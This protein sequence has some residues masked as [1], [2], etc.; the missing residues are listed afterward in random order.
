ML[1]KQAI[2]QPL[3][4]SGPM[5]FHKNGFITINR[6]EEFSRGFRWKLGI[7][8]NPC[9]QL[10]NGK[11]CVFC[12]FLNYR[13]PISPRTVGRYFNE[14]FRNSNLSDIRRLE[15]Y[16]SGSFFD[17]KEVSFDS[18]LEIIKS[19]NNSEIEE[20]ILE[21]RPEFI[22]EENLKPITDLINPKRITIA[23]GVET[24]DDRLRDELSKGFSTKDIAKSLSKIAKAGMNFQAY[25][26]LNP[27]GINN[28]RNAIIDVVNSSK[29]LISLTKKMDCHLSLALQPFFIAKNSKVSE[30]QQ[31]YPVRPPWLYTIA[32]TL[33]L[34]DTIRAREKSNLHVILGNENDNVAPLRTPSNYT[35]NGDVCSCTERVRSHLRKINISQKKLEENIHKILESP[36]DCR[37]V[38]EKEISA[39][40]LMS[41]LITGHA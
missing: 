9:V 6:K 19:I 29:K 15:L 22:T 33:K 21:S 14:V 17:D 27:P 23:M 10:R 38:W 32:L 28:D 20:T 39:H 18:R 11:R 31:K 37:K 26:L 2:G 36:C 1:V 5:H 12:G 41:N 13:N 40:K 25:L 34:L 3:T 30:N 24:M 4:N 8:T 7:N 35:G 16:V